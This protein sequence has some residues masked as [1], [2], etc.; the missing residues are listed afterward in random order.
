MNVGWVVGRCEGMSDGEMDCWLESSLR[1]RSGF[2]DC[3][4]KRGGSEIV[5]RGING[6]S[7]HM[8]PQSPNSRVLV[9]LQA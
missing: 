7:A 8:R 3:G 4:S 1:V 9:E 2:S 6:Q 5:E